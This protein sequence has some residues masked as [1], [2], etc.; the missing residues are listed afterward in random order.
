MKRRNFLK[1]I[2]VSPLAG[3]VKAKA[4]D[5]PFLERLDTALEMSIGL[6][7]DK[8]YGTTIHLSEEDFRTIV[9]SD[10]VHFVRLPENAHSLTLKP[11]YYPYYKGFQ[12]MGFIGH[13]GKVRKPWDE[14]WL[15]IPGFTYIFLE[16]LEVET[17]PNCPRFNKLHYHQCFEKEF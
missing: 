16:D 7:N 15:F 8:G 1:M 5:R 2:G 14:S 4:K 3:L 9:Q 10:H 17:S 11:Y 6:H 12:V 13:D